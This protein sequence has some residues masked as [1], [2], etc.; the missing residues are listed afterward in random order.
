MKLFIILTILLF[1][2]TISAFAQR[3]A[4]ISDIANIRTG[5]GIKYQVLWK[6]EKYFPMKVKKKIGSWIL[7]KDFEG[8]CG[9]IS[10]AVVGSIATVITKYEKCNIRSG[11]GNK[12]K[13]IVQIGKG[14]PFK[15]LGKKGVWL[16]L[17]H[18]DK[19]E[20]WIHKSLVW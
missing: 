11:P 2:Y 4:V 15:V 18:A 20:G 3:V 9:W 10:K 6:A 14:I 8:D 17:V 1:F 5:P 12:Y 19:E 13:V 7:F 16:H